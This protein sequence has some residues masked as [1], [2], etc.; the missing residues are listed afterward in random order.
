MIRGAAVAMLGGIVRERP[1]NPLMRIPRI[2]LP[3]PLTR[4]ATVALDE[5]AFNHAVRVLRLNV[6]APLRLF[7]GQGAACAAR[8][9]EIG[10]RAAWAEVAEA[11]PGDV[12]SPLRVVLVQGVARGEKTDFILQKAVEL[13]VAVFQPVF[14]GRGGVD[15]QGERLERR[16]QHW[17]GVVVSACEQCG[18][19]RLPELRPLLPLDDWLRL[20]AE[21]G[22]CL[23]LD[24]L[25]EQGLR[26]LTP[27][28]G[29]VTLLIGPEGGLDAAEIAR[30]RAAGFS[31]VRLG[32]R[33]LRT[34]T[35]GLAALAALQAL[36]GDWV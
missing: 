24:P 1:R 30:A 27:P 17:H 7:D 36:W 23:L 11:L 15:L 13:G 22:L 18:R 33:V 21:P 35:A 26:T 19:N 12:E 5:R 9:V 31:G 6:G 8:L 29:A 20:V 25:A 4:G 32:P 10:K 14:T 3:Q 2:Y 16:M 34:E 28:A